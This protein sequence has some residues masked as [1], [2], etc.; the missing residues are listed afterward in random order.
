VL[1]GL[2][3][4]HLLTQDPPPRAGPVPGSARYA[5]PQELAFAGRF[6]ATVWLQHTVKQL[7]GI[8]K[9][10]FFSVELK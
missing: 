3:P 6:P 2:T 7:G 8:I 5:L 10:N 9:Q 1:Q 4:L